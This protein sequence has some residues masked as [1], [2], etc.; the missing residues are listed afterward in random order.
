[1]AFG[2][3]SLYFFL[4][5]ARNVGNRKIFRRDPKR[6]PTGAILTIIHNP[7]W[8]STLPPARACLL[9]SSPSDTD[10]VDTIRNVMLD[11]SFDPKVGTAL[12]Q[13]LEVE[14]RKCEGV[15]GPDSQCV[16]LARLGQPTQQI[17]AGTMR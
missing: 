5:P 11:W 2:I 12:E 15:Y 8:I 4:S 3:K 9:Y 14:A 1:M 10:G 17:V 7:L 6:T 13:L 16:G